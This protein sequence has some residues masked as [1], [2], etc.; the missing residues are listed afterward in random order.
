MKKSLRLEDMILRAPDGVGGGEA[1][2]AA[3][4]A[5]SS[6]PAPTS[7]EDNGND[8]SGLEFPDEDEG[9]TFE[10]ATPS[11]EGDPQQTAPSANEPP[12]PTTPPS[13]QPEQALEA[14]GA[15]AQEAAKPEPSP[16]EQPQPPQAAEPEDSWTL[17]EKNADK[18]MENLAKE[19]YALSDEDIAQLEAEP[20]AALPKLAAKVHYNLTKQVA[21]MISGMLPNAFMHMQ[22]VQKQ[23]EAAV[24]KFQEQWPQIDVVKYTSEIE[25]TA[26]VYRQMNP[27]ATQD[28][29]ISFVG[30]AIA[31][32]HKL[33]APTP[34]AAPG[35]PAATKPQPFVPASAGAP[36]APPAVVQQDDWAGLGQDHDT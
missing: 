9:D 23:A 22:G 33:S 36:A 11:T 24:S 25:Q 34:S 29:V 32:R 6:D 16:T 3:S 10:G 27:K 28:E 26:N 14:K 15:P 18:I 4:P 31:A 8:F 20:A 21:Q 30:A 17:F 1:A 13:T 5:P 35:N 12:K 19:Q 2:P 7:T